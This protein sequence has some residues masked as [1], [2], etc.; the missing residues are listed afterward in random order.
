MGEFG[1][2]HEIANVQSKKEG[3]QTERKEQNEHEAKPKGETEKW[4]WSDGVGHPTPS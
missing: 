2:T 1:E 3:R 4:L